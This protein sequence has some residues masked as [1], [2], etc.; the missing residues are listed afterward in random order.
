MEFELISGTEMI[1]LLILFGTYSLTSVTV[2]A[3]A[4]VFTCIANIKVTRLENFLS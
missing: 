3:R 4:R 1:G 2:I